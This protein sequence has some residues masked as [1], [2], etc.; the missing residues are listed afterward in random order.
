MTEKAQNPHDQFFKEIFSQQES[1]LDFI[2]NYV[3]ERLTKLF[4]LQTLERIEDSFVDNELKE[5]LSDLLFRVKLK[6]KQDAFIYILLEH[7]SSP[8]KWV[9][10]QLL[11]YL[12]RIFEKSQR[13]GNKQLPLVLPI[14]FYHGKTSWNISEKF[15]ALFDLKDL[16][17]LRKFLPEFY[18]HLCD[19]NK[20]S[21]DQLKG[22]PTLLSAVRVLKYIF[23]KD[24]KSK[25]SKSFEPLAE[26]LPSD[27]AFERLRVLMFYLLYSNKANEAEIVEALK[28]AKGDEMQEVFFIDR[29]INQGKKESL[30]SI[31]LKILTKKFGDSVKKIQSQIEKL[32]IEQLEELGLA[33]LD[34]EKIEDFK[35]WK[36]SQISKQS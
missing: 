32:S 24:L 34:F 30:V 17:E 21:D 11:R 2:E 13:E 5:H 12:V 20:F 29:W 16:E 22:N 4:D 23:R 6:N 10:F 18:Y 33:I 8:D 28:E 26:L 35:N 25:L 19:L 31:N 27:A 9:S 7:K 15:S 36:K 1:I 3:P 14:V